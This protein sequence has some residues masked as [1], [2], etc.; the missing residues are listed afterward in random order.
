MEATIRAARDEGPTRVFDPFAGSATTLIAAE[1]VGVESYGTESHPF[2]ARLGR[3]KL[4]R[5]SSA[6][7]YAAFTRKVRNGASRRK[8]RIGDYPPL[9]HK[10]FTGEALSQLDVLR[11]ALERSYDGSA[12]AQLAWLTLVGILRKCSHVGTANWQYVLPK[13][14]KRA[15]VLPFEAFDQQSAIVYDDMRLYVDLEGPPARLLQ[16]DARDCRGIPDDFA[17]LVVTSPPYPNNFDYADATRLE[18]TFLRE[19]DGWGDLQKSVRQHLVRSCS[20]HVPENA[21]NLDR[22]LR[23]SCLAPIREELSSVCSKLAEVRKTRGGRK[24]YHVMVACYFLDLARAWRSLRRVCQSPCKVCFVIGDSAPYGVY[25]P[26]SEWL[27]ALALEAGF[28]TCSFEKIRN[29]N[30]KWK[31]RKHRVPLCEGRLWVT[32]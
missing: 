5:R 7:E 6:G 23:E 4:C 25:V 27:E 3:A 31:N 16:A 29:R 13:K 32:G 21:V 20:Q 2:V 30:V 10:C 19:I 15:D 17:T 14:L 8:P 24:T 18:M 26:V 1:N 11:R 12:T 9:I 28:H 22:V